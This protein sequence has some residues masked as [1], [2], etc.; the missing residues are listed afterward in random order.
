MS[1][2]TV[3][4]SKEADDDLADL[5]TDAPDRKAVTAAQHQID[6]Y[7]ATDPFRAGREVSEGLRRIDVPPLKAF[8]EINSDDRIVRI[9]GVARIT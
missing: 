4:S 3:I 5:W 6:Q 7:L 2:F 8:Y 1:K 9:T